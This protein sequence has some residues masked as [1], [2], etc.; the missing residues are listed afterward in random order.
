MVYIYESCTGNLY[1]SDHI[2]EYDELYCETCGDTDNFIGSARNKTGA[3]KLFN[4][5]SWNIDYVNKFINE[6]DFN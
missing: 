5:S 3:K 1:Y 4:K 6:I 2:K